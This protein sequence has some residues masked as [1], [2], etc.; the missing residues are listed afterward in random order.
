MGRKKGTP[1]RAESDEDISK[2]KFHRGTPKEVEGRKEHETSRRDKSGEETS[3]QG[4]EKRQLS[5]RGTQA[6]NVLVN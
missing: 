4:L 5:S 1:E 6:E 2:N 3:A